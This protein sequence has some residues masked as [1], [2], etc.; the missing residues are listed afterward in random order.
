MRPR[1]KY[2]F[3]WDFSESLENAVQLVISAGVSEMRGDQ[4]QSCQYG[5]VAGPGPS[6]VDKLLGV[7]PRPLGMST[8]HARP[9]PQ[10]FA[11]RRSWLSNFIVPHVPIVLND[12]LRTRACE[13]VRILLV[14]SR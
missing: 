11:N 9:G 14:A 1:S 3:F 2:S 12:S 5:Q 6:P 8:T 4:I 13:F 10:Q 7:G